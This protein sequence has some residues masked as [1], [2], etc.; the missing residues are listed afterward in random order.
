VPKKGQGLRQDAIEKASWREAFG[1]TQDTIDD[2]GRTDL[3]EYA[4][5]IFVWFSPF[6]FFFNVSMIS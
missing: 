5:Q 6:A 2:D 1:K 3:Y 4:D